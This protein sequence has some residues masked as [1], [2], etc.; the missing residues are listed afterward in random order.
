[1]K[2]TVLKGYPNYKE[3]TGLASL[4]GTEQGD[5][6]LGKSRSEGIRMRQKRVAGRGKREEGGWL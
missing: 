2:F 4:Q 1:M 6:V 3:E 5:Q